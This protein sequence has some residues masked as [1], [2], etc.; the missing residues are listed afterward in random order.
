MSDYKTD[1]RDTLRH[2]A[3]F[4][5]VGSYLCLERGYLVAGALFTIVSE[6]M[7]APSAIRHKSWSTLLVGGVFL[8][9]ACGTLV[10]SLFG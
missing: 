9:L 10:R 7:L 4:G 1:Y 5:F 3:N 8:A 6:L 2:F